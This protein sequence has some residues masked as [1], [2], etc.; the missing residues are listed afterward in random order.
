MQHEDAST[1]EIKLPA[2]VA[3]LFKLFG[4][5][6][7]WFTTTILILKPFNEQLHK[8]CSNYRVKTYDS[9]CKNRF[10]SKV[11]LQG[12]FIAT[13]AG[14]TRGHNRVLISSRLCGHVELAKKSPS[15]AIGLI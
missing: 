11:V 10:T 12:L 5:V 14:I 4:S 6:A 7:I 9:R 3:R 2:A 1:A 8:P 15:L 13:R